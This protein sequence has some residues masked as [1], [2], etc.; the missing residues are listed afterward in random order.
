MRRVLRA[1][2][3]QGRRGSPSS[4]ARTMRPPWSPP[5]FPSAAADN[6]LLAGLPKAKV[7]ATWVPWT[8]DRLA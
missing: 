6:E 3:A 1:A 7:A 4:A 5:T 8:S 2:I